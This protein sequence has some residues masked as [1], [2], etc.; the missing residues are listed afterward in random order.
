MAQL[1][2]EILIKR[3]LKKEINKNIGDFSVKNIMISDLS[4]FIIENYSN[5]E[6]N[7]KNQ[8]IELEIILKKAV[9]EFLNE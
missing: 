4:K 8:K 9:E 5:K 7:K 3:N 1:Y 6:E 2:K